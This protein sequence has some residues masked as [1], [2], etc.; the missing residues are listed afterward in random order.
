MAGTCQ[1]AID[2]INLTEQN[3]QNEIDVLSAESQSI[4]TTLEQLDNAM[5]S[6][7]GSWSEPIE[8]MYTALNNV[9]KMAAN[10]ARAA[11]E[12]QIQFQRTVKKLQE[13]KMQYESS[14]LKESE[15]LKG[16]KRKKEEVLEKQ[17]VLKERENNLKFRED[18]ELMRLQAKFHLYSN[19]LNLK[20]NYQSKPQLV[21]GC[22]SGKVEIAP[23][24]CSKTNENGTVA[25]HLWDL[26][27]TCNG[28]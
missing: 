19:T 4:I 17:K 28:C 27:E 10:H 1:R 7:L 12:E 8:Q 6:S 16:V 18:D 11:Q 13:E 5:S 9:K 21:E 24:S 3:F 20:W 25:D 22:V 23:F 14:V 2:M 26:I 15:N